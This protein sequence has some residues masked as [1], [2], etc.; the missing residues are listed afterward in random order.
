MKTKVFPVCEKCERPIS[1]DHPGF[2]FYGDVCSTEAAGNGFLFPTLLK[3]EADSKVAVCFR[4]AQKLLGL[5]L[6]PF[7]LQDTRKT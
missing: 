3:V 6:P 5:Q 7:T 4:C 2:V 1:D